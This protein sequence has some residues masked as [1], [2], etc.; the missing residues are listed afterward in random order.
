MELAPLVLQEDHPI[1]ITQPQALNPVQTTLNL[2]FILRS[3]HNNS[4]NQG[5][6][7]S[8]KEEVVEAINLFKVMLFLSD[9]REATILKVVQEAQE[10]DKETNFKTQEGHTIIAQVEINREECQIKWCK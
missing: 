9:N 2:S 4:H 8:N 1:I 5:G 3:L 7:D 10:E 6:Q